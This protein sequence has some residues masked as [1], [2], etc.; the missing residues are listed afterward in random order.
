MIRM[1]EMKWIILTNDPTDLHNIPPMIS[2]PTKSVFAVFILL[3]G[4]R[5]FAAPGESLVCAS[6][7]IGFQTIVDFKT[8]I[9]SLIHI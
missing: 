7:T 8:L 3:L 2:L 1:S 5:L 9:L 6:K 4:K